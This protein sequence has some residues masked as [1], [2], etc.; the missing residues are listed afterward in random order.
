[1]DISKEELLI[2]IDK[3]G[4]KAA[5]LNQLI[6]GYKG[7]LTE[8]KR[9][10]TTLTQ[11]EMNIINDYLDSKPIITD[12]YLSKEELFLLNSYRNSTDHGKNWLLECAGH[13]ES[14]QK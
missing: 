4:V 5:A 2:K 11:E 12:K 6:G 9:G 8:W 1:M 14:E 13:L 3:S 7:R 10:R